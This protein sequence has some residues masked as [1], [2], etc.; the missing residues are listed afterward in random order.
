[1]PSPS[2]RAREKSAATVVLDDSTNITK[3]NINRE[4]I[5]GICLFS[6]F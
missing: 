1:M 6:L 4:L 3:V 2:G 5:L